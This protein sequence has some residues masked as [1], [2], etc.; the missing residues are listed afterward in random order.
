MAVD[1]ETLI[2]LTDTLHFPSKAVY[3]RVLAKDAIYSGGHLGAR[4][5]ALMT[6]SVLQINWVMLLNQDSTNISEYEADDLTVREINVI[7]VSLKSSKDL[8]LIAKIIFSSIPKLV[9]L[10]MRFLTENGE[11]GRVIA[12][13]GYKMRNGTRNMVKY[14]ESVVSRVIAPNQ[15]SDSLRYFDFDAQSQINLK[16]FYMS[17][18]ANIAKYNFHY[19]TGNEIA[20]KEDAE[21]IVARITKLNADLEHTQRAARAE[22]QMNKR[23]T[24]VAKARKIKGEIERLINQNG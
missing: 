24:L 19:D 5:R 1:K 3:N 7:D 8:E 10:R 12:A 14:T 15:E 22:L 4:Q 9:L 6:D 16:Q 2:F 18:R 21:W 20:R 11:L 13:A 23:V 17:Y